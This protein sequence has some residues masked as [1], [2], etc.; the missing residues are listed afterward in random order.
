VIRDTLADEANLDRRVNR[1]ANERLTM[2]ERASENFGFSAAEHDRLT[3]VEREL[4]ECFLTR[5][6][7]RAARNLQRFMPDG[8]RRRPLSGQR[9]DD[10]DMAPARTPRAGRNESY[11]FRG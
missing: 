7:L 9:R 8:T 1:L 3:T 11:R 4:D 6:R 10:P 2:F 5:R